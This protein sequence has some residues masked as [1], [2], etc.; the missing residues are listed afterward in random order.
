ML[1]LAKLKVYRSFGGDI[2]GWA[3]ASRGADS[4]GITDEDWFL[5][6]ES[7]QA[8][9]MVASGRASLEFRA[10]VEQRLIASTADEQTLQALR[11]FVT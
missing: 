8:L 1:T 5:I 2:D 9:S 4:A 10:S 7:Q 3:R 6:G 11:E